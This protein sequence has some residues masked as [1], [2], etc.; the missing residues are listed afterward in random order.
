MEELAD[1]LGISHQALSERLRRGHQGL[2]SKTLSDDSD[3]VELL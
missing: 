3:T 1:R 2:I